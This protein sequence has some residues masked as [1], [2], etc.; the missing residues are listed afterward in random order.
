MRRIAYL[1]PL[2]GLLALSLAAPALATPSVPF[3]TYTVGPQPD[4]SYVM[5]PNQTITPAG[6]LVALGSPVRGKTIAINPNPASRTA[7]VLTMTGPG[8]VEVFDLVSGQVVQTYSPFGNSEGSYKGLTYSAD[9]SKLYLSQDYS[10]NAYPS[11]SD[12]AIANVD[13]STGMLSDANT[14]ALPATT[15]INLYSPGVAYPGGIALSADGS[16]AF[17]TLNQNNTLGVIDLTVAAPVLKAQIP[18]GNI[19]NDAIVAPNG[20]VYVSNEGG[21][22]VQPGEHFDFSS[23]TEIVADPMLDFASTATVSVIDPAKGRVVHTIN[24]GLHPAGMTL[25]GTMLY[26]ADSS[27]ETVSV[28]DTT[29]NKV[30]QKIGIRVPLQ[31]PSAYGSNPAGLVVVGTTLYVTMYT[32][33]AIA[34]VDLTN[35]TRPVMGYIPTAA[36]PTTIAYDA[37]HNQLVVADDIGI[38][39]QGSQATLYNVTGFNTHQDTSVV[40]LIPLPS[41]TQLANDTVQVMQNNHWDLTV[42]TQIGPKYVNPSAPPRA[43]PEHL[44]EPS[45]IKK[46]FLIIKENRTYDQLFGALPGGNGDASLAVFGN[47]VPNQIALLN[48]FAFLD[49]V[50]AP[51]RQSADGHP[52]IVTGESAYS[53]GILS[54][55]WVRSYPGGNSNDVMTYTPRGFLWDR[56]LAAG[57]TARL[58]GEWSNHYT[59]P[60][61]YTWSDWYYYSQ[62]LEGK[63]KG[64][65]PIKPTDDTEYPGNIPHLHALL[66]T[67]FPSF[68][69]GIPDQ[70]RV[71]YWLPM[72]QNQVATNTVPDLT[73]MWIMCDHTAGGATGFPIPAAEQADNDLAVGRIVEAV[74]N[75]PIWNQSAIFVEEDDA[76]NGVDHIDGHRQ[77]VQVIS[78]YVVPSNGQADHT[79]YTAASM[80]RTIEQILGITPM[81]QF[82]LVASP[83][84]TVFTDTPVNSAPFAHVPPTIALD[85]LPG[86]GGAKH[87]QAAQHAS[88]QLE[89]AWR[90][91]ADALVQQGQFAKADQIDPDWLN[92]AIWYASTGFTRPYPGEKGLLQPSALT[93]KKQKA[94]LDD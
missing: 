70:Y 57:H 24:V 92:H 15:A 72:F 46:V 83:M 55:Y 4:G 73:V 76:Q 47:Y 40:N 84:R 12:V 62:I 3:P 34:V 68:N 91:A 38:G 8:A 82:D 66:D 31:T 35:S 51:S 45:L 67:H 71:D 18:V 17:V 88:L 64:H 90:Q 22:P 79:T 52:W 26:V 44:G 20:Y 94:D 2:P 41:Q 28:I 14:V 78:P 30:V 63:V 54:P 58:Y 59:V 25:S 65:S 93:A 36:N 6:T 56:A 19:P 13:P 85:T 32:A 86:Q 21:R 48:R 10:N 60:S 50:Y 87:G 5:S 81:T 43:I 49:N 53:N 11:Y 33:N 89:D 29:S 39:D 77:P 7:A 42:N 74:S 75:S 61:K 1:S 37:A 80:N 16:S 69:L 9:G 27:G 23:G